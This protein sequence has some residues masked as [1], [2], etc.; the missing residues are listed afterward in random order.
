MTDRGM[1]AYLS[2]IEA[3]AKACEA[4]APGSYDAHYWRIDFETR[5]ELGSSELHRRAT[6]A[7]R[8]SKKR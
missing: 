4:R 3:R 5:G 6:Q 2:V 7:E 1:E 8:R